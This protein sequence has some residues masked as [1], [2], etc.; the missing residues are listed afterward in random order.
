MRTLL[1]VMAASLA[2]ACLV[3]EP[4][5]EPGAVSWSAAE[6]ELE[7]QAEPDAV[8]R[9]SCEHHFQCC[10][11]TKLGDKKDDYGRT[12]CYFCAERCDRE[13]AWPR[14]TFAGKD[15]DYWKDEYR[16]KPPREGCP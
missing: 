11:D 5:G 10:H 9:P 4:V 13:G 3:E 7:S 6:A 15:C 16:K 1:L 8:W 2:G 14:R 12:R